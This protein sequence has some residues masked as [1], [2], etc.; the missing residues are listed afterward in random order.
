M[1]TEKRYQKIA[2]FATILNVTEHEQ[3]RKF[4]ED[5][6]R[7]HMEC[8][9]CGSGFDSGTS[10]EWA[11]CDE[12]RLVFRT[13]FHHMNEHGA[14]EYWTHHD[15]VVRPSL[16][17]GIDIQVRGLDKNGIKDHIADRFHAWLTEEVRS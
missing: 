11:K 15:V 12:G 3:T 8:A 5:R 6:L 9:P 4:Y 10:L 2:Q 14:Y 16:R 7:P 1:Q 13:S 17:W